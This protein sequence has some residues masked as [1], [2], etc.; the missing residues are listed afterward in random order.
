VPEIG[1]APANVPAEDASATPPTNRITGPQPTDLANS[2]AQTLLRAYCTFRA[3]PNRQ[4]Y[5]SPRRSSVSRAPVRGGPP[6]RSYPVSPASVHLIPLD[7]AFAGDVMR[8]S[9]TVQ[10]SQARIGGWPRKLAKR[11][12]TGAVRALISGSPER[13]LRPRLNFYELMVFGTPA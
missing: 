8:R 11:A 1:S 3:N 2:D 13:L 9:G 10:V 7:A 6:L 5:R 4:L 12:T